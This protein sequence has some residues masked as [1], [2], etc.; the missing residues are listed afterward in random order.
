[1]EKEDDY[2]IVL[3]TEGEDFQQYVDKDGDRLKDGTP[4]GIEIKEK[5]EWELHLLK[6]VFF[7]NN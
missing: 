7:D 1:M 3:A 4:V 5:G 2:E 6:G